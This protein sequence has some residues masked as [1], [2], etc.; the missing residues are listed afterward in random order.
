MSIRLG[1][2]EFLFGAHPTSLDAVLYAY[3]APLLKAP[4]PNCILQNHLKACN[5]LHKY[6]I[7]ISQRYF[8]S[9]GL[10]KLWSTCQ[11]MVYILSVA[12]AL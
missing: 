10:G 5:N 8:P 7:R 3:L 4:F 6:V 2:S 11:L 9:E 12:L 1:D